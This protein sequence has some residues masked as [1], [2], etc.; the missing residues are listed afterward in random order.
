MSAFRAAHTWDQII[1]MDGGSGLDGLVHALD[2]G[3]PDAAAAPLVF[4]HQ[5]QHHTGLWKTAEHPPAS[6]HLLKQ[7]HVHAQ[8]QHRVVVPFTDHEQLRHF[9]LQ[10]QQQQQQ[11]HP[12]HRAPVVASRQQRS[13]K[14]KADVCTVSSPHQNLGQ[15][16]TSSSE[17]V[18][19]S[20]APSTTSP[21][22]PTT[23]VGRWTT[24]EHELFLEGLK[25]YGRSWKKISTLV[26]TRTL[27]QIRTHAQKYLQKQSRAAQKLAAAA[28]DPPAS[29]CSSPSSSV[30]RDRSISSTSTNS[31]LSLLD[32]RAGIGSWGMMPP[33]NDE[34]LQ[35]VA[36]PSSVSTSL[37]LRSATS[38]QPQHSM[39]ASSSSSSPTTIAPLFSPSTASIVSSFKLD[40]LLQD[41]PSGGC[42]DGGLLE[43][44]ATE[45]KLVERVVKPEPVH[46]V[47]EKQLQRTF[48]PV[49]DGRELLHAFDDDLYPGATATNAPR[50]ETYGGYCDWM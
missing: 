7:D 30:S 48:P 8:L 9:Y 46:S 40:Q 12:Y 37:L 20:Q 16:S 31:D 18:L 36:F 4:D 49:L 50:M 42:D 33:P 39:S 27:V 35:P 43:S 28:A 11:Q 10:Q 47:D 44:I 26:V 32:I 34:T 19:Y 17:A 25:L 6:V 13:H 29:A 5:H 2:Y 45:P 3:L 22:A 1:S 14:R 15:A 38:C 41:E 24:K 23:H 21:P